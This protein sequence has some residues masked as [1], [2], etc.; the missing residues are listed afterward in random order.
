VKNLQLAALVPFGI[1]LHQVLQQHRA[2]S[3]EERGQNSTKGPVDKALMTVHDQ[4]KSRP[5]LSGFRFDDLAMLF[6][7]Y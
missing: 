4:L 1:P 6:L 3:T 5:L 2:E 7:I